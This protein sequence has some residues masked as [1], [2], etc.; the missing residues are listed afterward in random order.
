MFTMYYNARCSRHISW[1]RLYCNHTRR[2]CYVGILFSY[3]IS[4]LY[5]NGL[6]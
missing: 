1:S 4:H 6:G 5:E 2:D 3:Y